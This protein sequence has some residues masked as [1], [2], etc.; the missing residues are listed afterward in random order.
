VNTIRNYRLYGCVESP[1]NRRKTNTGGGIR[2]HTLVPQ[3][4]ILIRASNHGKTLGY[5]GLRRIAG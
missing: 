3:D 5:N 4:R 2:A 1:R